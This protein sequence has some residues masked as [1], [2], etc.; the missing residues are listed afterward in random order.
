MGLNHD[1]APV[2]D[3]SP[4]TTTL[5]TGIHAAG[6]KQAR[7][8]DPRAQGAGGCRVFGDVL[9]N[10]GLD[11]RMALLPRR[12]VGLGTRDASGIRTGW[13]SPRSA[14]ATLQ[15]RESGGPCRATAADFARSSSVATRGG[16]GLAVR[17]AQRGNTAESHDTG[18]DPPRDGEGV[19]G[20]PDPAAARMMTRRLTPSTVPTCWDM[21]TMALP[22]ALGSE[23]GRRWRKRPASAQRGPRLHRRSSIQG[24]WRLRSSACC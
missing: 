23:A 19:Y 20:P 16:L 17:D 18:R 6:H 7:G 13:C 3:A 15:T 11:D 22:E 10:G 24:G 8:A 14:Q 1:E 4:G 12:S 5:R 2:L 9:A 21:V